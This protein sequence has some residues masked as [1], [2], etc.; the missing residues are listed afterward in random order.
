MDGYKALE[1]RILA[2]A[3]AREDLL[4]GVVVGSCARMDGTADQWSDLDLI[5]FTSSPQ[6][7]Q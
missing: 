4:A 6:N 2:W 7:Y 1:A 3:A 5:L